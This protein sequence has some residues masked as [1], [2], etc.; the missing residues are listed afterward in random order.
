MTKLTEN[1]LLHSISE[2][3][4]GIKGVFSCG[5]S[6][7]LK[8]KSFRLYFA[9]EDSKGPADFI[10]LPVP[11]GDLEKLLRTCKPATFGSGDKDVFDVNY[12]DALELHPS[13]FSPTFHPSQFDIFD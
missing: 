11:D 6:V 3:V 2:N 5:G 9:S 13:L 12:R 10:D 8:H 7:A 1:S 4:Q